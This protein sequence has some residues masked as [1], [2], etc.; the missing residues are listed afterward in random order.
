MPHVTWAEVH[1]RRLASMS[2]DER[3]AFDIAYRRAA[4]AAPVELVDIEERAA[5]GS[6]VD[7]H[8][9][10]DGTV[11]S[12]LRL[13]RAWPSNATVDGVPCCECLRPGRWRALAARD[14]TSRSGT[15]V[16]R[17]L[18]R[19]DRRLGARPP[20][21]PCEAAAVPIASYGLFGD[22]RLTRVVVAASISEQSLGDA[23]IELNSSVRGGL[24]SNT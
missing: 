5:A 6:G 18:L 13:S 14:D 8:A 21:I 20:F 22:G 7:P 11:S 4:L 17:S 16:R 1:R 12:S 10:S 2:R 19:A 15:G 9:A 24:V 23:P 3:E